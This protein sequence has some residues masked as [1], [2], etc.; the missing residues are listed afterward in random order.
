MALLKFGYS[1]TQVCVCAHTAVGLI[2]MPII[3]LSNI[4]IVLV[5]RMCFVMYGGFLAPVIQ[6][7]LVMVIGMRK[8]RILLYNFLDY[9]ALEQLSWNILTSTLEKTHQVS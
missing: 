4:I 8:A 9:L 3:S 5:F 7:N 1:Y 6:I 2:C